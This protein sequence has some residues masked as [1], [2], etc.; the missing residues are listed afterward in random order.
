MKSGLKSGEFEKFSAIADC[1]MNPSVEAWKKGGGRVMGYTCS[2][3]PEELIIA[4]GMLPFRI[5]AT[6]S[7]GGG[8]G[9]DYFNPASICSMI[10]CTFGKV[11]AGEYDF[12]NGAII[13]GG[14]DGNRHILDN[15]RK[16]PKKMDF[17]ETIFFPHASGE[18]MS[19]YFKS[20]LTDIRSKIEQHFGVSITDDNLRGAIKLTNEIRALQRELYDLRKLDNPPI[21]G[22]ETVAVMSAGTSMPKEE[23]RD[24]LK[25]LI[26][27]LKSATIPDKKY[28]ARLMI[29]GPGYDETSMCDVVEGLGG[30]VAADLTCFGGKLVF[31]GINETEADPLKAIADYQ[32]IVRP[33]CPK[34]LNAQ[35]LINKVVFDKIRDLRIDGIIG[36]NFLCCETWGG[37]LYV[38]G[39]ELKDAG[40]PMLRIEREYTA[41]STGQLRTRL[42][43]FIE[44]ISGGAL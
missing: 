43:A 21:T 27:E 41:D 19:E 28:E 5:R 29:V 7:T 20:E 13:G 14:C 30:L 17:L 26:A 31:G 12:I 3:I 24:D 33:L 25:A 2:F 42:Q 37:A 8:L 44:T 10:R 22:S 9:D 40:I 39:K 18:I 32:V 16:S 15:W 11:L 36:Q 35:T 1:I 23:Y 34:N 4:A 38:L 6:G